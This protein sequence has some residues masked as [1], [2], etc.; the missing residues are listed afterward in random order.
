M[1]MDIGIRD[2]GDIE[3]LARAKIDVEEIGKLYREFP[4][5]LLE[6][7]LPG[8]DLEWVFENMPEPAVDPRY[9]IDSGIATAWGSLWQIF[10]LIQCD[11]LTMAPVM[12]T[13]LR[14]ALLSAA[15][16]AYISFV[17]SK[18]ECLDRVTMVL[19]QEGASLTR[20]YRDAGRFTA[21]ESLVPD[22]EIVAEQERR[23]RETG[24]SNRK[25]LSDSA[26][27]RKV[28]V[29]LSEKLDDSDVRG[30]ELASEHYS[31]IFHCMSGVSHG[32]GWTRLVPGTRSMSGHFVAE[33]GSVSILARMA[34]HEILMRAGR[35]DG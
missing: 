22:P 13:M 11:R 31:W 14:A 17:D 10:E 21:L 33:L 20:L 23:L 24:I 5:N 7:A 3:A 29:L 34:I 12:Q 27:L 25:I 2:I 28:A 32:Y 15:R 30:G 18:E 1:N 8:S 9:T 16:V 26:M 35:G 4:E 6:L 19:A